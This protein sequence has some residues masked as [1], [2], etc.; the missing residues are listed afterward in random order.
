MTARTC[1]VEGCGRKHFSKGFCNV[2]LKR[3]MRHGDPLL[4]GTEQGAPLAWLREA[5]ASVGRVDCLI[6]PYAQAAGYGSINIG[7]KRYG[8]HRLVCEMAHGPAGDGVEAAHACGNPACCNPE[9]LRWATP[10]ENSADKKLHGTQPVGERVGG[11]RFKDADV[12]EMRRL[13]R[14]GMTFRE[15]ANRFNHDIGATRRIIVGETWSHLPL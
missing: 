14:T 13:R 10:A 11:S 1:T 6:W 4:G 15:I 9:H 3:W 12:L 5:A 8:V 2:H 7:G